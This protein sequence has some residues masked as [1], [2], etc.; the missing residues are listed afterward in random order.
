MTHVALLS[1]LL[2]AGLC[3]CQCQAELNLLHFLTE[4][5]STASQI[6]YLPA[7]MRQNISKQIDLLVLNPSMLL[8]K[9]VENQFI[10]E[11]SAIAGSI[12]ENKDI[13]ALNQQE[14]VFLASFFEI[15]E[16]IGPFAVSS[17][18]LL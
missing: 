6:S 4:I 15:S 5:Q 11:L 12:V 7:P 3:F 13:D 10:H 2:L 17:S 8:N 16:K 9:E 1:W 18:F 14:Q